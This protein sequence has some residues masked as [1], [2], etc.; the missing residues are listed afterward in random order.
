MLAWR[1]GCVHTNVFACARSC[2]LGCTVGTGEECRRRALRRQH[3]VRTGH[4]SYKIAKFS[5]QVES[6]KR[7]VLNLRFWAFLRPDHTRHSRRLG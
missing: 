4:E 7:A 2:G 6:R 5:V 1:R 3:R